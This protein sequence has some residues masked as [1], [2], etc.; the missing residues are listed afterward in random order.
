MEKDTTFEYTYSSE[1]QKEIEA[2]RRKYEPKTEDKMEQLR[3]LDKDTEKKGT[4]AAIIVGVIGL[5]IFGTGLSM[6]MVWKETLLVAGS[7]VGLLGMILMASALFVYKVVTKKQR[8][9]VAPQ[10]LALSEELMKQLF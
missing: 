3:K 5:L 10:I 7:M 2:I 8:E 6:A 4:I 1:R 9:K